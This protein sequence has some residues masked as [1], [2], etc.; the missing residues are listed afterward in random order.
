M[1][2]G[3]NGLNTSN[4]FT[5]CKSKC[6]G[7]IIAQAYSPE[8]D[9]PINKAFTTAYEAENKKAPPQFSAQ[10]FTG[11]Q[12]FVEA[13]KALDNKTKLTSLSLGDLRTKL[14]QEILAGKYQTVLGDIS[15]TPE[16]EIVQKQFYV[17]EIKMSADGN[18]GK[19]VFLK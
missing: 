10:A 18:N 2:I 4:I 8:L 13:L 1:I 15:F 7:V 12:V 14:N 19:F 6:D 3:G 16:G 5:V 9:S 17:A 11:V